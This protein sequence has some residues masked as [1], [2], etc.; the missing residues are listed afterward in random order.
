MKRREWSYWCSSPTRHTKPGVLGSSLC[1]AKGTVLLLDSKDRG[2]KGCMSCC[3]YFERNAVLLFLSYLGAQGDRAR[4]SSSS[5]TP[6]VGG[7]M[8]VKGSFSRRGRSWSSEHVSSGFLMEIGDGVVVPV[9]CPRAGQEQT[10]VLG[11]GQLP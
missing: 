10:L 2:K 6:L 1:S 3:V 11:L 9:E 4:W 7:A 5:I 8:A